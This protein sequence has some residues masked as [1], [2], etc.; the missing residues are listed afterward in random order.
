[1]IGPL[2]CSWA[3]GSL[4]RRGV[5]AWCEREVLGQACE[6]AGRGQGSSA[7]GESEATRTMDRKQGRAVVGAIAALCARRTTQDARRES[8]FARRWRGGRERG[9]RQ[10]CKMARVHERLNR[11]ASPRL[12]SVAQLAERRTVDGSTCC[13]TSS[14]PQQISLGLPFESGR[15][16]FSILLLYFILY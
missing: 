12:L 14:Y 10:M 4:V 3:T 1:M 9:A 15:R 5:A 2:A 16:D 6:V 7:G 13:L 11:H 8:G